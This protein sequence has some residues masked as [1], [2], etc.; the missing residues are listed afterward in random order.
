[1]QILINSG[2]R[3]ALE[4]I[5]FN[6]KFA[7][8]IFVDSKR[9]EAGKYIGWEMIF[10]KLMAVQIPQTVPSGLRAVYHKTFVYLIHTT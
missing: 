7:D 2:N 4:S 5:K 9:H 3:S 10:C 6:P 8:C 1:M